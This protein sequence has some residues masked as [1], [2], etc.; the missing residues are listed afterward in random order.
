MVEREDGGSETDHTQEPR[1]HP[2]WGTR[3]SNEVR[4]TCLFAFLLG[5]FPLA[6][7]SSWAELQSQP[8]GVSRAISGL[9]GCVH[10]S[11][12]CRY[13]RDSRNI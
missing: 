3:L 10:R 2:S 12:V 13:C 11:C 4:E 7:I 6:F 9:P 1:P 8:P 5:S